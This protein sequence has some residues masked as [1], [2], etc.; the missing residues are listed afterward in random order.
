VPSSRSPTRWTSAARLRPDVV[1]ES[2]QRELFQSVAPEV[3]RG[4]YLVPKV[5]D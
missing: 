3:E 4:L 2:D 1:T 5:I